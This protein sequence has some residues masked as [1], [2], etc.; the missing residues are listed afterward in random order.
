MAQAQRAD[1]GLAHR[2]ERLGK[3][4]FER[5]AIGD[6][7]LVFRR[8]SAQLFIAALLHRRLERVDLRDLRLIPLELLPL[9]EG[10]ELR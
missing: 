7:L 6:A 8:K 9:A 10:E 3:N 2:G 4:G 5:F 1:A